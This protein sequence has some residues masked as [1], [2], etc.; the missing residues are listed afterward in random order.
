MWSLLPI[1]P[2]EIDS[3]IFE[4]VMKL[5]EVFTE[6]LLICAF[7]WDWLDVSSYQLHAAL[8]TTPL[9]ESRPS[10]LHIAS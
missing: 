4:G 3:L 5:F 8:R 1:Q 9:E 10:A 7:E 2:P 6:E